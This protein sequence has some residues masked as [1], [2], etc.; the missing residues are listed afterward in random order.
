MDGRE[1]IIKGDGFSLWVI[2]S[3][4]KLS[5]N[6]WDVDLEVK[7]SLVMYG[8]TVYQQRDIRFFS[9][10]SEGYRYSGKLSKSLP[11]EDGMREITSSIN[12]LLDC[13]FNGILF[14]RYN[15][16]EEYIGA[17]S[18]SETGLSNGIVACISY[19]ATRTFRI[20]MKE[21][22]ECTVDPDYAG[23]GKIY[24]DIPV[25]NG[26]L[27][28]MDGNFQKYF[29]HEIPVQKKV[30]EPRLSLTFRDHKK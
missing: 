6:D 14:N 8:K 5:I 25:E 22:V 9:D 20:R 24:C 21:Q 16:G 7:P 19:G 2:K 17:H 18:D 28:V 13:T 11:M 4:S 15:N 3:F 26:D 12:S 30:T 1:Y 27:L 10:T 29:T 23:K